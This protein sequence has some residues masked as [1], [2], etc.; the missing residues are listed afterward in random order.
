ML[1]SYRLMQFGPLPLRILLCASFLAHRVPSLAEFGKV[2]GFVS[3]LGLPPDFAYAIAVLEIGGAIA[4][5]TGVL[6]RVASI[7]LI[8]FM[9]STTLVI[10][11]SRGYVGGFEVDLLLLAMAA[12]LLITGPGR[13]SIEWDVIKREI[14]PMGR[15][16]VPP[17]QA[18]ISR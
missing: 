2:Q 5:L 15:R 17:S 1:T 6:T 9:A 16:L 8:A 11:L 14:F 12:S 18:Q 7:L 10:K 4:V 13:L 3:S